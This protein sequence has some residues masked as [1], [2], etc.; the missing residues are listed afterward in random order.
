MRFFG[1]SIFN[2][3]MQ[4]QTNNYSRRLRFL[5]H[6]AFFLSGIA[7]VLIGQILPVLFKKLSLNDNHGGQLFIAQFVGSLTGNFIYNF[8]VKRFGFLFSILLGMLALASGCLV[9]NANSWS[10]CLIGFIVLG[11]GVGSTLTAINMFIAETNPL[12]QAEALNILNF[13]WG[14]GAI[15]SQPYVAFLGAP[16]SIFLPTS[17]LAGL[18]FLTTVFVFFSSRRAEQKQSFDE[19]I[20]TVSTPIWTNPTAWLITFF[21][22]IHVGIETGIGGWLTT[23][24][25]RFPENLSGSVSATPV[26]FLFFVIGRGFASIFLK[27]LSVNK[28]LLFSLLTLLGGITFMLLASNYWFLLFGAAVAGFGTSGIFPTNLARFTRIFGESATRRAAPFFICGGFGG[29]FT[30]WL[31]GYISYY[32][33]NLRSGIFVLLASSLILIFLQITLSEKSLPGVKS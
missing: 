20:Q 24:S 1:K 15:I 31:I 14:V 6:F 19:T 7:T 17:L 18:F 3:L 27:F 23:Y 32:S 4:N 29:A 30:T 21:N 33:N 25:V 28:F 11:I 12:R 16:E 5:L 13:F 10:I 9:I 8:T 26:F 22:F 2:F